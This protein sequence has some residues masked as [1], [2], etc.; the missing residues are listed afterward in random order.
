MDSQCGVTVVSRFTYRGVTEEYSNQYWF[1]G[2]AP[3]TTAA[4]KALADAIIAQQKTVVPNTV[5]LIRAYGYDA[6]PTPADDP[7]TFPPNVWSYDYV[8][9]GQS[10]AGTLSNAAGVSAPG[11]AAVWLRWKTT[12]R[13][14]P[15]GKPI[16]LRKY[17][18]GIPMAP[19]GGDGVQASHKTALE[20][21]GA[22]FVTGLVAG[23]YKL[24]DKHHAD[25][26]V[27]QPVGSTYITT[28]TLRRRG[29]RPL[30][31]A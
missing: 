12:R 9:A 5:V 8:G 15:G 24:V 4:W 31:T 16:Y 7:T 21:M 20:T 30:R 22:A 13:T 1:N 17:Y 2:A 19:T 29:K 11:D 6:P 28:R 25:D 10:V 23:A 3:G 14:N 18:H 26:V 27:T